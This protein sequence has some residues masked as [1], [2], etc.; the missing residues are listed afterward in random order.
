LTDKNL[1]ALTTLVLA[2]HCLVRAK[3][4]EQIKSKKKSP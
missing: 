2:E 3:Q 1:R 4:Q